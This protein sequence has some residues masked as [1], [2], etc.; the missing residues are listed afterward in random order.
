MDTTLIAFAL[1][2][3]SV[4]AFNPCGFAMLPAYLSLVVLGDDGAA[5]GRHAMSDTGRGMPRALAR[6]LAATAMMAAGF[7]VVFGGFGLL[8]TPLASQVYEYLPAA[9]MVIGAV[10][11]GLGGWLLAGRQLTLLLPKLGSGPTA[12]LGSMF[13]YG[14]A[15]ALASLSCTIGPFLAVTGQAFGSGSFADGVLTFVAYGVGMTLVVGVLAVGSA[16]AGSAVASTSRK[17]LPYINR[18]SGVLLVLAGAYVLYYGWYELRLQDGGDP[19]DP[20][21]DAATSVQGAIAG[22]VGSAGTLTVAV[23]LILFAVG[24]ALWASLRKQRQKS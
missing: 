3:G 7:V 23:V 11:L 22:A 5:A 12:R 4:A 8:I 2:A 14:I 9:T 15:Y 10:L 6:A 13:S 17:V 24:T 20:I 19:S 1:A 16:V 21:I 18:I